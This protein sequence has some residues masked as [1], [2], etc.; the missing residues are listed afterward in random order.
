MEKIKIKSPFEI[1][2]IRS[3]I[4]FRVFFCARFY[5]PVFTILFLD[6]GL[7]LEQFALL[8][9][10]WA[11]I[12]V[13][14]EVP[15]GALADVIGRRSLVVFA[16][17]AM[18]FEMA[19][20]S[21]APMNNITM[22]FIILILNRIM[23][24]LAEAAASGADEA[25]AY[26]S[27]ME[28]GDVN[29]WGVVLEKQMRY[30]SIAMAVA[31][32]LGAAVY[33]PSFMNRILSVIGLK[34]N[35]SQD[36]TLRFPLYLTLVMS[37]M[38][39]ISTLKMRELEHQTVPECMDFNTCKN[40][41]AEAFK[42]TMQAAKWVLNKPFALLVIISAMVF[43]H[44]LRMIVTLDSQYFRLIEIPEATFGLIGTGFS[45]LGI[46]IPRIALKFAEN[47]SPAY[48][49]GVI[50]IITFVGI[51]GMSFFIPILGL[52]PTV[53]IFCGLYLV[54]FY[55]SY[56][57]NKI[58]DSS[59]R[60]TVLSIKGLILNAAYGIIGILYSFLV[61]FQRSGLLEQKTG[62]HGEVLENI[63][64]IKSFNWFPGYFIVIWGILLIFIWQKRKEYQ[65]D[66]FRLL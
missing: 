31:M 10:V 63:V 49:L 7:S 8:N 52:L 28:E 61:A 29:Q 17:A 18:V 51:Y 24:G 62:V 9:V 33:D 23:S 38:A 13:I 47:H 12:I 65:H 3:F 16:G 60:A 43:D 26:D 14:A 42:L 19:L 37:V 15:S 5:Y 44:I 55:V 40:S 34:F 25:L 53:F 36:I 59:Q 41:V 58:T 30:R 20:I 54:S 64:F 1:Q 11:A 6:F 46:F 57:L 45:I 35:L 66:V 50:S 2:N 32:S 21:F 27:L 39:L 48:N 4:A 56:Y 22:L